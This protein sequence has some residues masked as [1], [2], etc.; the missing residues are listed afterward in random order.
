ME[1]V[2]IGTVTARSTLTKG[3]NKD[4]TRRTPFDPPILLKLQNQVTLQLSCPPPVLNI[5]SCNGFCYSLSPYVFQVSQGYTPCPLIR[6]TNQKGGGGCVGGGARAF[7]VSLGFS[8]SGLLFIDWGGWTPLNLTHPKSL[9]NLMT[10]KPLPLS[11][12]P[13]TMLLNSISV[14]VVWMETFTLS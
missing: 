2:R 13:S 10:F 3:A 14:L 6:G 4:S 11:H 8:W 1:Y 5:Q 9:K 7:L 12:F